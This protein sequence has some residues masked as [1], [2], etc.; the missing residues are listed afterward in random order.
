MAFPLVL[1]IPA[2]ADLA[3]VLVAAGFAGGYAK[4]HNEINSAI[5]K[6]VKSTLKIYE[7]SH[8]PGVFDSLCAIFPN[9]NKEELQHQGFSEKYLT[10]QVHQGVIDILSGNN[11]LLDGLGVNKP[12]GDLDSGSTLTGSKPLDHNFTTEHSNSDSSSLDYLEII[13]QLKKQNEIIQAS[14]NTALENVKNKI[15]T[16]DSKTDILQAQVNSLGKSIVDIPFPSNLG[17]VGAVWTSSSMLRQIGLNLGSLQGLL[18]NNITQAKRLNDTMDSID[19]TLTDL[20]MQYFT[21]PRDIRIVNPSKPNIQ[22]SAPSVT[23]APP[24]VT[25]TSPAV[26]ISPT[27]AIDNPIAIDGFN[28]IVE[29]KQREMELKEEQHEIIKENDAFSKTSIAVKDLDGVPVTQAIPRELA[30]QY[31]ATHARALTDENSVTIDDADVDLDSI[32]LGNFFNSFKVKLP[33]AVTDDFMNGIY[34]G[35]KK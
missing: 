28:D 12:N 21:K 32:N 6:A 2:I 3:S 16:T 14:L 27:L 18:A 35:G 26:N 23:V 1:A 22:V 29:A 33:W 7:T 31:H 8:N 34:Y 11:P 20:Y 13:E 24:A 10:D 17:L 15:D 9:I 19:S 5:S 4:Y 30:L 25:V